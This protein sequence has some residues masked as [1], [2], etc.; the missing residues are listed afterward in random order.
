MAALGGAENAAGAANLEIAHG[1]AKTGAKRAVLLDR[2][3]PFASGADRHHFARQKQIGVSLV[4][5]A[6]DA[7]AKLIEIRQAE[8]VSPVDDDRVRVRNIE[9]AFDD[10]S[11]N[12]H[13]DF[14]RNKTRHHF[15]ELVRSHLPV[16]NFDACLRDK[17]DNFF[18][19]SVDCLN[20]VVQKINLA[21]PFELS[22]DCVANDA[23]V[24]TADNRFHRQTVERRRFDGGH[25]FHADEG[26]IKRAR[27][28]G[29]RKRQH[30]DQL[31]EF[32]E[33]FFV[34]NAEALLFVD[35]DQAK[36]LEYDVAGNE[37][38]RADDDVDAALVK[39]LEDFALLT[40][41]SKPAEHF[42]PHRVIEH[43]LA[44]NLEVLLREDGRGR[45]HGDLPRVHDRL[46]LVGRFAKWKG[47]L[48]LALPLCVRPKRMAGDGFALGLDREHFAGVIENG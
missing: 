13:V 30:V 7:A 20:P 23:L 16:S 42:N 47:M 29:G 1:N 35:H 43:A 28:R 12:E 31:E 6:T 4:F 37:A 45:E 25:V 38:M 15:L 39:K 24:V 36:I 46:H 33:F 21:L 3:N 9:T 10:G 18:P 14:S 32:L 22:I 11:A 19:D 8:T 17:I 27:N 40:L 2:V 26:K 48:E 41:R 34:Q 44:K 5:G